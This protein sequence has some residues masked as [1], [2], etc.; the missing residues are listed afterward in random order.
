MTLHLSR[1]Q[2]AEMYGPTTGDQVRLGDTNLFAQVERDLVAEGAGYGNEIKFGGGKVIR[3]GMGQSS[4]ALEAD[5]LDLVITNAL[6]LDPLL[7]V[8]KA[9][10]GVKHGRIVGLGHAGNPGIQSGLGSVYPDPATGTKNPMIVGA[11]T[12]HGGHAGADRLVDLLR[13]DEMDVA[14]D[15]ARGHEAALGGENLGGGAH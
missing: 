2:Y 6:I 12:D 1:R 9:D 14:V 11:A 13:A 4:I 15:A 7:G 8:I 3:D 10:I 5:S